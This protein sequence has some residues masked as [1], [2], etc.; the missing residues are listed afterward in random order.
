MLL[1]PFATFVTFQFVSTFCSKLMRKRFDDNMCVC[2]CFGLSPGKIFNDS[3]RF[4]Y[5]K[6]LITVFSSGLMLSYA[7]FTITTFY[8]LKKSVISIH[9]STDNESYTSSVFY[10]NGNKAFDGN[11]FRNP[12]AWIAILALITSS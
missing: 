4:N 7:K 11:G 1:L 10:F 6:S 9:N 5:N 2:T 12:P 3:V 8:I